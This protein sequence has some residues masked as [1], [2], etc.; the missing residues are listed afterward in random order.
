MKEAKREMRNIKKEKVKVKQGKVFSS[1]QT[2]VLLSTEAC[3][4]GQ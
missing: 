3:L 1:W 4:N 2:K